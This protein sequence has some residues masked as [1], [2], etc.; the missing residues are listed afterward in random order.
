M[1]CSILI[2]TFS[3]QPFAVV[4][5]FANASFQAFMVLIIPHCHQM[6]LNDHV[7]LKFK[8]QYVP[9]ENI[10]FFSSLS[11]FSCTNW[12]G[13]C[14]TTNGGD[15]YVT[16]E[17]F[18]PER[19][20]QLNKKETFHT[21]TQNKLQSSVLLD[22]SSRQVQLRGSQ[23]TAQIHSFAFLSPLASFS[24]SLLCLAVVKQK[25]EQHGALEQELHSFA[26]VSLR[27]S[28]SVAKRNIMLT[29]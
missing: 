18:Y 25:Q 12:F 8:D 24:L 22:Q 6:L 28:K 27:L 21:I 23:T 3:P 5:S 1:H 7:H 29:Y 16:E 14:R 4:V 11:Q 13:I 15:G 2:P 9:S 19:Q 26:P 20:D 17:F 10:T